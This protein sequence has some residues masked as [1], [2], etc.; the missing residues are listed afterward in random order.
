M[1][2]DKRRHRGHGILPP[3]EKPLCGKEFAR[4]VLAVLS[5]TQYAHDLSLNNLRKAAIRQLQDR[6]L[7]YDA[8]R[9]LIW[10]WQ[11]HSKERVEEACL[12]I[13]EDRK[14]SSEDQRQAAFVLPKCRTRV[15]DQAQSA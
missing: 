14:A 2:A 8:A 13:L 3:E 11:S 10:N 5:R 12:R 9:A 4:D 15:G 1:I 7:P 6:D